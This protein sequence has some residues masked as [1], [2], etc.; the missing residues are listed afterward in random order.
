MT[1]LQG[2]RRRIQVALNMP[3]AQLR[4]GSELASRM[5]YVENF[6]QANGTTIV[7]DILGYLAALDDLNVALGDSYLDGSAA[8][9]T[10]S[11]RI[12]EYAETQGFGLASG[13]TLASSYQE[14]INYYIQAI[15]RDLGYGSGAM[16]GRIP[17]M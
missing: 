16:N 7:A 11:V 9:A 15:R 14:R 3:V 4:D 12:D 10:S 17:V 6:D 13:R 1:F 2:D 5:T 8:A